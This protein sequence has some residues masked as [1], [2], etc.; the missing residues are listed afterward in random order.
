MN[1]KLKAWS[2]GH[3]SPEDSVHGLGGV[4]EL[5]VHDQ[6]VKRGIVLLTNCTYCGRQWKGIITWPEVCSYYLGERVEGTVPTRQGIINLMPCSGCQKNFR[7][8]TDWDEVRRY[9]DI[10][11]RNGLINPD[12]KRARSR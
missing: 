6:A 4:D 10:G 2:E 8:V 7:T 1:D 5:A 9:V 3:S 11:I 12:I